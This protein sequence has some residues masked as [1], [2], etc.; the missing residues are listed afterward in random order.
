MNEIRQRVVKTILP[1]LD[2][3]ELDEV[4]KILGMLP[5]RSQFWLIE[6]LFALVEMRRAQVFMRGD[7]IG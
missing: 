7:K 4:F 5:E 6:N 2:D 1:E 3:I